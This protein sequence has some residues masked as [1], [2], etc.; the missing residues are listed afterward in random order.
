MEFIIQNL[1]LGIS[2]SVSFVFIGL[3]FFV[4]FGLGFKFCMWIGDKLRFWDD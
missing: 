3:V 2:L 1:I 4:F